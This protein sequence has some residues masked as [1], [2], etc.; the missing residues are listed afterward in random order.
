MHKTNI[1]APLPAHMADEVFE[2]IVTGSGFRLERII[3][4]GH[5]TPEGQWYDQPE[6][7]WV[8][9]LRGAAG[10]RCEGHEGVTVLRPGDWVHLPAHLKH[11]VE[12]TAANTETVWLALHYP[13]PP[14]NP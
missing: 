11:R 14:S 6:D 5:A 8:M 13:A 10:L 12:W 1:F 3:S 4:K 9:L 7:E 2:P